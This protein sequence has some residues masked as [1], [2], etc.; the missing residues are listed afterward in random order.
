MPLYKTQLPGSIGMQ[1]LCI[2][3]VRCSLKKKI[4]LLLMGE[5]KCEMSNRSLLLGIVSIIYMPAMGRTDIIINLTRDH[6][7]RVPF[8][9]QGYC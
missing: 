1:N 4:A 7:S 2:S 8:Q 3:G 6:Y 9:L 5:E